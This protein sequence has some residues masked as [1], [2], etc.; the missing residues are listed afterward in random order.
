MITVVNFNTCAAQSIRKQSQF[1]HILMRNYVISY[2]ISNSYEQLFAMYYDKYDL[3][4][5]FYENV[6][7]DFDFKNKKIKTGI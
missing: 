4:Y 5:R 7:R 6:F 1:F 3:A 2:H